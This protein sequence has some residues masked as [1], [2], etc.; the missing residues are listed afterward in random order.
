MSGYIQVWKE[1]HPFAE[2][3]IVYEKHFGP[4]P[5]G[6]HVHHKNEDTRDNR[7]ENLELLSPSDHKRMH[8]KRYRR[9]ESGEWFKVCHTCGVEKS[10]SEF[11]SQNKGTTHRRDCKPCRNK[12]EGKRLA[13]RKAEDPEFRERQ[14]QCV[15]N[16]LARRQSVP[17]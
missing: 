1:G 8:S 5:E 13:S 10:I 6:F 7:I 14:R 17:A 4:I 9:D 11:H 12:V 16:W 15:R 2:H 3:R